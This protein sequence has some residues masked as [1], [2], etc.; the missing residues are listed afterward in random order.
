MIMCYL[1]GATAHLKGRWQVHMEKWEI[2]HYE[3]EKTKDTEKQVFHF[4]S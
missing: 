3:E 2:E 4:G 1:I